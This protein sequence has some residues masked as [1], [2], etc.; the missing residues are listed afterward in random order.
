ML[1]LDAKQILIQI[2]AFLVMLWVMKR[3][4][5]Q[6]LLNVLEER[7]K[8]IQA[9]F[10][11][12]ASQKEELHQ[13]TVQYEQRMK[14]ISA[15]ARKK[16]QEAV[17]E[18][19]KIGREI[20]E[21]AQVKSKETLIKAKSEVEAEMAKMKNQLKNDMVNLVIVTTEKILKEKLDEPG[22]KK[23]IASFIEEVHLK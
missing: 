2:I 8:K 3:F 15:D 19:Q 9:E 22:Q 6:P 12:I 20:Q 14:E 23:L 4:G 7:R 10:D 1:N 18:G 21:E 16:I 13:V 17:A 5:W 11:D